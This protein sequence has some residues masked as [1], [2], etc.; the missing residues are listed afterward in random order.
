MALPHCLLP[1]QLR[2][3]SGAGGGWEGL[4]FAEHGLFKNKLATTQ[5]NPRINGGVQMSLSGENHFRTTNVDCPLCLRPSS[6]LLRGLR[7]IKKKTKKTPR[8]HHASAPFPPEGWKRLLGGSSPYLRFFVED[9]CLSAG[10]Y[11]R[12]CGWCHQ[13]WRGGGRHWSP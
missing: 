13:I 5:C 3:Y 2:N 8:K 7:A 10:L 1:S 12:L 6:L 4:G 11:T 9:W